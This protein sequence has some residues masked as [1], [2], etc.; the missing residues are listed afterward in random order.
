MTTDD[1]IVML[2]ISGAFTLL[3]MRFVNAVNEIDNADE[4]R[5]HRSCWWR[6]HNSLCWLKIVYVNFADQGL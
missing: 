6:T 3:F 4:L 1:N 2:L 5:I